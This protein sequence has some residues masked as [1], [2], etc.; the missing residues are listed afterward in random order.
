[1]AHHA[2]ALRIALYFALS[3]FAIVL[4]GLTA[5]RLHDTSHLGFFDRIVAELLAAAVLA[6][7]W[8]WFI[9]H[10][11]H[12]IRVRGPVTS[13]AHEYFGL[14]IL[15]LMFLVGAAIATHS[16]GNLGCLG[17]FSCDLLTT[18]VVFAWL[19]FITTTLIIFYTMLF[20]AGNSGYGSV[21]EPLH[22]RWGSGA[23]TGPMNGANGA[24]GSHV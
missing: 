18:I 14:F 15:W 17:Q 24:M 5:T 23:K 19:C 4:L 8:S 22:S 21:H 12:S 10:T 7:L 20:L 11:I 3:L 2:P 6:M 16:W 13:F 1:M 9:M